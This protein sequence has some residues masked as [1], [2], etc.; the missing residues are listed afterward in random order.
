MARRTAPRIAGN[1][2]RAL[3]VAMRAPLAG[4][5]LAR[6]AVR[7]MGLEGFRRAELSGAER[8]PAI[9]FRPSVPKPPADNE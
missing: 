4:R 6:I 2:L 9:S 5:A 7:Q 3:A 1:A 8:R